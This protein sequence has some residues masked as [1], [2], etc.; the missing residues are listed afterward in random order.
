MHEV[1]SLTLRLQ[2]PH[3][4]RAHAI[5][6]PFAVP[7]GRVYLIE[8]VVNLLNRVVCQVFF[9]RYVASLLIQGACLGAKLGNVDG[10]GRLDFDKGGFRCAP[11]LSYPIQHLAVVALSAPLALLL[12]AIE[13]D[14]LDLSVALGLFGPEVPLDHVN[15]HLL[16]K[17]VLPVAHRDVEE[18]LEQVRRRINLTDTPGIVCIELGDCL[19]ELVSMGFVRF[20]HAY[21]HVS[22]ERGQA[23]R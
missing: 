12:R 14:L 8:L 15:V 23:R 16:V 11:N 22:C 2:L 9:A 7:L 6:F 1:L 4:H 10:S 21:L 3:F 5:V 18:G 20:E 17:K 13:F 19:Q